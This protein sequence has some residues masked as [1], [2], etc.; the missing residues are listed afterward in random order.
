VEWLAFGAFAVIWLGGSAVMGKMKTWTKARHHALVLLGSIPL[1]VSM[2]TTA[3]L[4]REMIFL[5]VVGWLA[6]IA[7]PIVIVQ[8][9]PWPKVQEDHEL[10]WNL[11][12][13][14]R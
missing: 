4:E 13:K 9:M 8:Q 12:D 10:R 14:R 7:P 11:R 3:G 1:F 5:A 2:L 6:I